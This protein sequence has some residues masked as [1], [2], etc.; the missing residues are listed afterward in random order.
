MVRWFLG[1]DE[2][3]CQIV[4]T[5]MPVVSASVRNSPRSMFHEEAEDL[6][7]R[8]YIFESLLLRFHGKIAGWRKVTMRSFMVRAR[9]L[10]IRW[11]Y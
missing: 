11:L 9:S 2:N 5:T 6:I 4:L 3:E 10:D 8:L 7:L 1:S